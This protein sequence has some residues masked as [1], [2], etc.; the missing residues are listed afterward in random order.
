MWSKGAVVII[1]RGDEAMANTM[2]SP[3]EQ[4][5]AAKEHINEDQA[6]RDWYKMLCK[7]KK[8]AVDKAILDAQETYGHNWTPPRWAKKITE[9]F[10]FVVYGICVFIER[11]LVL[12]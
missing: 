10:A 6:I 9:G 7:A 1:K 4:R 8:E 12:R 5:M 2:A 3:F 11:Y